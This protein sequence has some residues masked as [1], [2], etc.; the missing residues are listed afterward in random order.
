MIKDITISKKENNKH[1][2]LITLKEGWKLGFSP[3]FKKELIAWMK[4]PADS[5][6][7]YALKEWD[8]KPAA[9][10]PAA[11]QPQPILDDEVP[12]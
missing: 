2:A 8:S 9:S 10:Q 6:L 12:F 5:W 3:A 11:V 1:V 7:N 4:D